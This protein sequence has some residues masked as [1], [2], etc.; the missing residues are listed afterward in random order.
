[1]TLCLGPISSSCAGGVIRQPCALVTVEAVTLSIEWT[2]SFWMRMAG[3]L[4]WA[5]TALRSGMAQAH[6]F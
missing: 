5:E 2:F 1:M 6:E 3:S 4:V